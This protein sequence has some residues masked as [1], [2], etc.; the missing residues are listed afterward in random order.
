MNDILWSVSA[1]TTTGKV[2]LTTHARIQDLDAHSARALAGALY[3]FVKDQ[4]K[5]RDHR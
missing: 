5:K 1:A 4:E 3:T 2:R